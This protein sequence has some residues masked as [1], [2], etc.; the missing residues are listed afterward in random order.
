MPHDYKDFV[1]QCGKGNHRTFIVKPEDQAQ[2]RG[3][4]LTKNHED[5]KPTDQLVI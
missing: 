2:G 1:E 3:I 5:I 4:F